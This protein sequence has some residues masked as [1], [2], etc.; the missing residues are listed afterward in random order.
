MNYEQLLDRE[1]QDIAVFR[2][3]AALN[4][5]SQLEREH[6]WCVYT[7]QYLTAEHQA[8]AEMEPTGC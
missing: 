3:K 4:S 2:V 5:T 1:S 8:S 6:K 7:C